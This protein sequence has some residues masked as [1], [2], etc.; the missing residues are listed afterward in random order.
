MVANNA[1]TM[2]EKWEVYTNVNGTR[3]PGSDSQNHYGLGSV[4]RW[5]YQYLGGIDTDEVEVGFKNVIIR[6]R[7]AEGINHVVVWYNSLRGAIGVEWERVEK[8]IDVLVSTTI[9]SLQLFRFMI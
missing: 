3:V 5:L 6:P 9:I 8:K 7:I 1:T 4:G 2:W